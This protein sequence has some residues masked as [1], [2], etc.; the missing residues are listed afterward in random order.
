MK[1]HGCSSLLLVLWQCLGD[2]W[3]VFSSQ[4]RG[5]LVN[6]QN[7][8]FEV[9]WVKWEAGGVASHALCCCQGW[10][11]PPGEGVRGCLSKHDRLQGVSGTKA[12]ASG[13]TV[14]C[15][16]TWRT[17]RHRETC[18]ACVCV[19]ASCCPLEGSLFKLAMVLTDKAWNS[20]ALRQTPAISEHLAGRVQGC[21]G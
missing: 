10:G 8:D 12:T 4:K 18:H 7:P 9:R 19:L 2:T 20:G 11:S 14:Q 5:S 1:F 21:F 6:N 13:V 16:N 15:Y 17:E 3:L